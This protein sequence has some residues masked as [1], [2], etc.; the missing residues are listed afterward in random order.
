MTNEQLYE[1]LTKT[2]VGKPWWP[3]GLVYRR[4]YRGAQSSMEW[5]DEQAEVCIPAERCHDLIFGAALLWLISEGYHRF[6]FDSNSDEG[7]VSLALYGTPIEGASELAVV[8]T[9]CEAVYEGLNN[10]G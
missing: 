5:V 8:L 10:R 9:M 3:K 1:I 7:T 2:H 6:D 4:V